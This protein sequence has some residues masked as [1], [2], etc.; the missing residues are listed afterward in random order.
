MAAA[1]DA[2]GRR[3]LK[4]E[5]AAHGAARTTGAR[6]A[7]ASASRGSTERRAIREWAALNALIQDQ[8]WRVAHFRVAADDINYRRFFDINDLAGLRM[9]LPEVFEHAHALV[10]RL[11]R[12]GK[13]DG[14]RIDHVDGLLNPKEYLQRLREKTCGERRS[15]WSWRRFWRTTKACARIGRWRAHGL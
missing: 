14:L 15:I 11:L 5:L 3:E 1:G 7:I 4:A 9:E 13:L 8:H 6:E 10:F 2:A 12:E